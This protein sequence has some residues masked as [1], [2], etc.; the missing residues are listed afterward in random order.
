MICERQFSRAPRILVLAASLLVIAM[1]AGQAAF[2]QTGSERPR[3]VNPQVQSTL[4]GRAVFSDSG[5]PVAR[6]R[7]TLMDRGRPGTVNHTLTDERG[8][9][10]FERVASGDYY[11]TVQ[12]RDERLPSAA[13]FSVPI[14]SGDPEKD[15]ANFEAM[16][17]GATRVS[18]DGTNNIYLEVRV[19]RERGGTMSGRVILPNG[20]P[21][22]HS[23]VNFVTQ[24]TGPSGM[25]RY[26]TETNDKGVYRIT[27]LPPGEYL[28]SAGLPTDVRQTIATSADSMAPTYFPS[29]PDE[30][31]ATPVTIHSD[32][33]T[34]GIN[35]MLVERSLHRISGTVKLKRNGQPFAGVAV[36]LIKSG[37]GTPVGIDSSV[38]AS[39][40]GGGMPSGRTGGS[41]ID[42]MGGALLPGPFV[43]TD[44][45]GRWSFNNIPDGTYTI[46]VGPTVMDLNRGPGRGP[47]LR[48]S[49]MSSQ[50]LDRLPE[51][52]QEITIAG[53]DVKNLTI[54]VSEGGKISG[55]VELEGGTTLPPRVLVVSQTRLSDRPAA[56]AEVDSG[57]NFT[58]FGVPEG[59]VFLSALFR[60]TGAFYVKSVEANGVQLPRGQIRLEDGKEISDVRIVLSSE[61]ASLTGRVL[62]AGGSPVPGALVMLIPADAESRRTPNSSLMG[63][64]FAD[65][66]FMVGGPPGEYFAV[67]LKMA[68]GPPPQDEESLKTMA[69]G[70]VRVVLQ[71]GERKSLDLV[72]PSN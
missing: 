47:I 9:F 42:L 67:V 65:G 20:K 58:L 16:K 71:S 43:P 39:T 19:P 33:E 44:S 6:A 68:D 13:V 2:A 25:A 69:E 34:A 62:S 18:V 23:R 17:P 36:R 72:A 56:Y 59:E 70:G 11:V 12:P 14:P 26:S 37:D 51:K 24:K 5:E 1:P 55:V 7:V 31:S 21:A 40:I 27:G 52:R 45:Q 50:N 30:Q 60:P 48:G 15:A 64:T 57:G 35:V 54:E 29:A 61:V 41:R 63:P 8:E 28:V 32:Q 10:Q 46:V 3:Q 4:S 22:A 49:G 38:M 66:R 53:N